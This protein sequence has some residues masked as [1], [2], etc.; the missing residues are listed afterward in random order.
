M[1]VKRTARVDSN[2]HKAKDV[3]FGGGRIQRTDGRRTTGITEALPV[4]IVHQVCSHGV[5]IEPDY[6]RLPGC[7]SLT[8][9]GRKSMVL[10]E[11]EVIGEYQLEKLIG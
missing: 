10:L 9:V 6:Y 5:L 3:V 2:D 7:E 1:L 4:D 11:V 8:K